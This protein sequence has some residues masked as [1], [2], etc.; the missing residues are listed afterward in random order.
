MS[1][2]INQTE[3]KTTEIESTI[4][5]DDDR[6]ITLVAQDGEQYEVP[7][8]HFAISRFVS[9]AVGDNDEDEELE[10]LSVMNVKGEYL[11]KVNEFCAHYF[12]DPM[13]KIPSP[14]PWPRRVPDVV[15]RW[16]GKF[17]TQMD[18]KT[19]FEMLLAG[20]YLNIPP[21]VSICAARIARI[22]IGRSP[23]QIAEY[24]GCE[25]AWTEEQ[26]EQLMQKEV[27]EG[28]PRPTKHWQ[29][30]PQFYIDAVL[31]DE[32]LF[33]YEASN[34]FEPSPFEPSP[35]LLAD[36]AKY[37]ELRPYPYDQEDVPASVQGSEEKSG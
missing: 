7:L 26:K 24:F 15:H 31:N 32:P 33:L 1:E 30:E 29:P 23:E 5:R 13:I 9:D 10:D 22:I 36:Q 8:K 37:G 4:S 14:L 35:E 16:Y 18:H 27:R 25:E 21:L 2:Q 19:L 6:N 17:I 3:Q 28:E 12:E 20:N 11:A 34:D